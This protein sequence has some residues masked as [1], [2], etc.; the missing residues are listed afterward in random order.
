MEC[1]YIVIIYS[2][3]TNTKTEHENEVRS[4]KERKGRSE[5]KP[6]ILSLLYVIRFQV[7][8]KLVQPFSKEVTPTIPSRT[9]VKFSVVKVVKSR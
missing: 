5:N 1:Y 8:L 4:T 7:C 9:V 2:V 3:K 6:Y